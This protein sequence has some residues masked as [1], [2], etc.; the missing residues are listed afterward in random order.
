MPRVLLLRMT[1][2]YFIGHGLLY[3]MSQLTQKLFVVVVE[4]TNEP[5]VRLTFI[6]VYFITLTS[7]L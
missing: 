1:R 6:L 4:V 2:F 3:K 7:S 5:E